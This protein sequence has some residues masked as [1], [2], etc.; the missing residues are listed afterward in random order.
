ME[1]CNSKGKIFE[2]YLKAIKKEAIFSGVKNNIID[3]ESW[4][5]ENDFATNV[6]RK[7]IKCGIGKIILKL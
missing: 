5:P 3:I 2:E 7:D 4:F 6:I 1:Y